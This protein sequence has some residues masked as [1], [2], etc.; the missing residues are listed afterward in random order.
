MGLS[1]IELSESGSKGQATEPSPS[2]SLDIVITFL[3]RTEAAATWCGPREKE[4][5]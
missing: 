4:L 5:G 3:P 1:G 2:A